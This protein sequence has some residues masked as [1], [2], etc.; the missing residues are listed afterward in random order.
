MNRLPINIDCGENFGRYQIFDETPITDI[1]D[2]VN[3]ACGFHGGDYNAIVSTLE[4]MKK[5]HIKVGAHP[6]FPDLQGFGRRYMEMEFDDLVSCI[7]YQIATLKG[8]CDAL[9][10]PLHHV[11]AHGVLYNVCCK[12]EKEASALVEAV[13]K[14]KTDLTILTQP[15]SVLEAICGKENLPVLRESFADRA[16]NEDLSLVSRNEPGAVLTD[17]VAVKMQFENLCKGKVIDKAGNVHDLISDTVCI[18]GDHAAL[19]DIAALLR[20]Y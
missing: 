14:M 8:L 3:V 10:I 12:K 4:S 15:G 16:Y 6:S 5:N 7:F 18:H 13:K 1:A 11:K 17:P 2:L 19:S 20:Y 9:Q